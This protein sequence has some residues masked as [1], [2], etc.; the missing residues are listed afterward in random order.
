MFFPAPSAW[1]TRLAARIPSASGKHPRDRRCHPSVQPDEQAC[2]YSPGRLAATRR[3]TRS[4]TPRAACFTPAQGKPSSVRSH[5][6]KSLSGSRYGRKQRP[7]ASRIRGARKPTLTL[8]AAGSTP[9][10]HAQPEYS[11]PCCERY[12][13]SSVTSEASCCARGS[14]LVRAGNSAGVAACEYA[15]GSGPVGGSDPV[16]WRS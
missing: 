1:A 12:R 4:H 16:C 7:S 3:H 8:L 14:L 2:Q 9:T 5:A 10:A 13:H 15:S 6:T 11:L